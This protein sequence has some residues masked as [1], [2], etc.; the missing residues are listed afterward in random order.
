MCLL[1]ERIQIISQMLFIYLPYIISEGNCFTSLPQ[2]VLAEWNAMR[3]IT[4]TG[5]VQMMGPCQQP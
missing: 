2:A 3:G 4:P 1:F 5:N